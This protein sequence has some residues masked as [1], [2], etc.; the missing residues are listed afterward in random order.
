MAKA[1]DFGRKP[2]LTKP[3][4]EV[5]GRPILW[6]LM[7]IY[8]TFGYKHFVLPLGYKGDMIKEYFM[9]YEWRNNDFRI[10]LKDKKISFNQDPKEDWTI[11]LVDT[12]LEAKTALRLLRVK[13]A[14]KDCD[15]FMLTYGDG[16]ADV[17]L[18]A[19]LE[20]HKQKGKIVTITGLHPISKYGVID[21]NDQHLVNEF[22]EKP[23]LNDLINGGFMVL[24]KKVFDYLTED[25]VMFED[26]ILPLLAEKGEVALYKHQG[27]WQCM[28]TYRDFLALNEMWENNPLWKVWEKQKNI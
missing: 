11:D 25:N 16:L 8:D 7:K 15:T 9:D 1:R 20:F 17:D 23:I 28:D 27:F 3:L 22:K 14:L 4:V 19:L 24:N 21:I 18:H 12:G 5:G 13:E 6:H 10:A 2:S 26:A